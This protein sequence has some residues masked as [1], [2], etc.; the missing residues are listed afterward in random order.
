[1]LLSIGGQALAVRLP[2][3]QKLPEA[4]QADEKGADPLETSL[5]QKNSRGRRGSA[6]FQQAA[7]HFI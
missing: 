5:G 3:V 6:L 2:W 1:M 4:Y 7:T